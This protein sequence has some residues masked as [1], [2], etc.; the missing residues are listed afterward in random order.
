VVRW[1][2]P[3][4][5]RQHVR[6]LAVFAQDAW[7]PAQWLAVP[8]GVRLE[9]VSGQA[10]AAGNRVNWTTIEP[11]VGFVIRLPIAGSILRGG[12]ARYGHRFQGR[13]FDF[14]NAAAL[15]GQVLQWQDANGDRQVQ[16]PEIARL[17]RVFGGPHSAVDKNLRRPFANEITVEVEKRFGERFVARVRFFRRDDH[18]LIAVTNAGVPFSSYVPTSVIDPG[19]DGIPGTTD[20]QS[21]TLFNRKPSAL[22]QDFFVLTN[23]PGFRGSDKGFEIEMLKLF[24][25]HWEAAG[26]FTAMHASYP[27]NPGNGVFQNDPGFIITDQSVFGALNADPN[28]LLFATGRTYFD[29]GFTGKLSAY[30]EAPYGMRLG[31]V[32]RYYDGLVFGRLLFVNGFE[33]GPFFVRA[34]PRGDFGA[35]RTQFNSTLDLRVARTFGFKRSRFS[36]DLDVFNLLNLNKNTLESDLTSTDFAKR[37]PLAIQA[38]RTFRLGLEWEF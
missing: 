20:D 28:T 1:N 16:P 11:R 6:N 19:N 36:L 21:L 24:A 32:A 14:G 3:T 9:N 7:R 23:P 26:N 33:Q 17:L 22:G 35:F 10:A 2:T 31:V 12:F 4:Q 30:Y 18:H 38:P 13:Y 37:I 5:A 15:G 29:R 8:V 25:R 34:T 27:T